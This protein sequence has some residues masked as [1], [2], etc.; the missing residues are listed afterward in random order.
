MGMDLYRIVD[1]AYFR[2]SGDCWEALLDLATKYGWNPAGTV[3]SDDTRAEAGDE[4][5]DKWDGSYTK[6]EYQIIISSDA[7]NMAD[8]LELALPDIPNEDAVQDKKLVKARYGGSM[9]EFIEQLEQLKGKLPDGETINV[10]GL[11]FTPEVWETLNCFEKLAG[12]QSKIKD[13]I[14][15]LRISGCRIY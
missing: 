10:N 12:I 5:C 6:N 11:G 14:D 9:G 8:A 7:K 1:R 3:P 4:F 13:F 2:W 15:Y